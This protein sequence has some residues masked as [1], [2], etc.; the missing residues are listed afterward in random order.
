MEILK[1][2]ITNIVKTRTYSVQ[3]IKNVFAINPSDGSTVWEGPGGEVPLLFVTQH[4]LVHAK[5][6]HAGLI[7]NLRMGKLRK[8]R[9]PK[10]TKD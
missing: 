4:L 6:E 10:L 2:R 8:I 1:E 9:I 5:D 3:F 7:N